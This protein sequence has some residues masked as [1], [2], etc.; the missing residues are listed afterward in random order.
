[1]EVFSRMQQTMRHM[2]GIDVTRKVVEDRLGRDQ[3]IIQMG[4][5][6]TFV[7]APPQA[8]RMGQCYFDRESGE[9]FVYTG[10]EWQRLAGAGYDYDARREWRCAY[11]RTVFTEQRCPTCGA[12]REEG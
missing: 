1:M 5:P 7:A 3:E 11:C 2:F 9:Q 10:T 12:G 4:W 6:L 8:P